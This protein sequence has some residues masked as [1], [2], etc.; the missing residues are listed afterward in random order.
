MF[1]RTLSHAMTEHA[2]VEANLPSISVVVPTRDRL[3]DMTSL[4]YTLL[5]QVYPPNEV[6]IVDDSPS[7]SA[8][9]TARFFS[10]EFASIYCK[11]KYIAR[12]NEGLTNARNL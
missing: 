9:E 1:K 2:Q 11:L 7:K 10:L 6:I 3:E 5:D 8:E 4:L 12:S